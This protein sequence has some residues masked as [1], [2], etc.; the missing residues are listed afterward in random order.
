[1]REKC[2]TR[3][4]VGDLGPTHVLIAPDTVVRC[5][6]CGA[7]GVARRFFD[8]EDQVRCVDVACDNLYEP[9]PDVEVRCTACHQSKPAWEVRVPTP[10]DSDAGRW[11][12]AQ[13]RADDDGLELAYQEGPPVEVVVVPPA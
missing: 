12:C 13:C 6:T 7:S 4:C 3:H 10:G 8:D 5:P 11:E 9:Q 1:M 2:L